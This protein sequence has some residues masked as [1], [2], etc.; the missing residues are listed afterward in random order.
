[1]REFFR[2][3]DS[4]KAATTHLD[5]KSTRLIETGDTNFTDQHGLNFFEGNL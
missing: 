4:R 5:H 3:G 1:M 2:A